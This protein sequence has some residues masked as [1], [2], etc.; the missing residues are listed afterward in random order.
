MPTINYHLTTDIEITKDKLKDA[1]SNL[2]I[3]DF[4]LGKD[5]RTWN[6]KQL[7]ALK[8]LLCNVVEQGNRK[9]IIFIYSRSNEQIPTAFNPL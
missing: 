2:G 5:N 7:Q 8:L 4:E 3:D 9:K 1:V 6:R